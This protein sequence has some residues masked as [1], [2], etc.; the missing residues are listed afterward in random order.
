MNASMTLND[1]TI[2]VQL[3]VDGGCKSGDLFVH[4]SDVNQLGLS[5]D[6]AKVENVYFADE[7]LM[8]VFIF[9]EV[10]VSLLLDDGS[11]KMALLRPRV[12]KHKSNFA[13]LLCYNGLMKLRVSQDY[14]E[15]TLISQVG[16]IGLITC[17]A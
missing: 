6:S 1:A 9:D 10:A 7:R 12:F 17:V 15:R 14:V 16:H 5:I 4:L 8:E 2:F 11:V 3:N 13:K